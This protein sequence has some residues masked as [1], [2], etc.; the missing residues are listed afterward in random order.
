MFLQH[1]PVCHH[2]GLHVQAPHLIGTDGR[3]LRPPWLA[4]RRGGKLVGH[5]EAFLGGGL[6]GIWDVERGGGEW[7]EGQKVVNE[8][9][10]CFFFSPPAP[11]E[12]SE[13]SIWC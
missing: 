2:Q 4:R 9:G 1:L 7:E 11:A 10:F 12:R 8:L 6:R 5:H 3:P 13:D